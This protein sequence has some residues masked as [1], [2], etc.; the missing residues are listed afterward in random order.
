MAHWGLLRH[1]KK[2]RV[3]GVPYKTQASIVFHLLLY[4][5]VFL[6]G[7]Q[8]RHELCVITSDAENVRT[9]QHSLTNAVLVSAVHV[10]PQ[11]STSYCFVYYFIHSA[12]TMLRP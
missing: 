11:P 7:Y 12:G 1:G 2:N 8:E 5:F 10:G 4:I 3:L 9:E 6:E